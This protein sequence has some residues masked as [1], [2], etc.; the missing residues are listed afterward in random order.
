MT[1]RSGD[2]RTVGERDIGRTGL[3]SGHAGGDRKRNLED[4]RSCERDPD[5]ANRSIKREEAVAAA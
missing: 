3:G 2:E 5:A 1:S 4:R